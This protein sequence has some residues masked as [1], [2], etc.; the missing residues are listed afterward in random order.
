MCILHV[1]KKKDTCPQEVAQ[2]VR[3]TPNE[4]EVTSLNSPSP[5]C[6]DMAKKKKKTKKRKERDTC[7]SYRL[8]LRRF[9]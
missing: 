9:F 2:S 1:I 7:D 3:T 4:A 6:A 5:S 8:S